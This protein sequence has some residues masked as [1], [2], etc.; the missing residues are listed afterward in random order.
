LNTDAYRYIERLDIKYGKI[1][2]IEHTGD[3]PFFRCN[4]AKIAETLLLSN[5]RF[6]KV[7]QYQLQYLI[8]ENGEWL[9]SLQ[10]RTKKPLF[11]V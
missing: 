6:K 7:Q 10:S 11:K 1:I 3:K 2:P 4:A 5:L 9:D 8:D